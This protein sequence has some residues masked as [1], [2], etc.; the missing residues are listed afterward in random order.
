MISWI[1]RK[2]LK[3]KEVEELETAVNEYMAKV[4]Q[5]IKLLEEVERKAFKL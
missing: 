4:Q 3:P 1:K 5:Q 2:V